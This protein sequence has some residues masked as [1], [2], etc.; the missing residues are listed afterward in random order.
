MTTSP[1]GVQQTRQRKRVVPSYIELHASS[2][3]SFLRS[4]SSVEALVARAAELAMPAL[5]LADHMTLAGVVRFQAAC[6]EQ[7]VRPIVG[8][9]LVV[10]DP[11]FGDLPTPTQFVAL[12]R[13]A[14]GYAQLVRLLTDANLE[15]PDQ[16]VIP[17]HALVEAVTSGD[18]GLFVFTGGRKGALSRMLLLKDQT[19]RAHDLAQ[20]YA[21]MF[22]PE[23]IF[24]ELQ[25]HTLLDSLNLMHR[26]VWVAE[27]AGL[28]C[29]ATN[30]VHCA[31]QDDHPLYDLL[32]CVRLGVTVDQPHAE[33]PKNDQAYLKGA[34]AMQRLIGRLPWGA[35]ALALTTEIAEQCEI[36]L[37]KPHCV[38]PQVPLPEGMTPTTQLRAL[39]ER[40]LAK[41]YRTLPA[42]QDPPSV[43]RSQL[44]HELSV[45][46][47]L[48]LEEFFLCVDER[49]NCTGVLVWQMIS[50]H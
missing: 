50:A 27:S 12:V 7:G 5:A 45:I 47:T 24:V 20:R 37:L 32:T 6:A 18:E 13:N 34:A 15:D 30:G 39:C 8:C 19:Q 43:Q 9:E 42:A 22:G 16:P 25:H 36:S 38:A 48:E 10:A 35:A 4:G 17:F 49:N 21:A 3:Y 33:R 2:A 14:A 44:E 31:R 23:R 26:L 11:Q 41:R 1:S 29:V 28:R 46:A 40:G